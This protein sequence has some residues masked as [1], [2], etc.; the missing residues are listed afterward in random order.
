[1]FCVQVPLAIWLSVLVKCIRQDYCKSFWYDL[2]DSWQ[3]VALDFY[4]LHEW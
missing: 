1:M 2:Q 3:D 4:K